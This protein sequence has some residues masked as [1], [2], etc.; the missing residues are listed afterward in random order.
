MRLCAP[1]QQL[2]HLIRCGRMPGALM[3][4]PR[5]KPWE[6][7]EMQKHGGCA[8]DLGW[9]DAELLSWLRKERE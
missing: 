6:R 7:I 3:A 9:E 4:S 2:K 5:Q 1:L 8:L